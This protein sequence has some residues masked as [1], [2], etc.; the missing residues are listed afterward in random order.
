VLVEGAIHGVTFVTGDEEPLVVACELATRLSVVARVA[1]SVGIDRIVISSAYRNR[2]RESF[3]TMGMALDIPR[4]R[5]NRK[6]RA[7]D[8]E[9]RRWLVIERDFRRSSGSAT[10]VEGSDGPPHEA[11][12]RLD[13]FVCQLWRQGVFASILTPNYNW[14]HRDH[15]HLDIRPD[16]PRTFLR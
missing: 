15:L 9:R 12:R 1:K 2:P 5:M 11:G 4:M 6:V 16:D 3:H 13:A 10:C 14:G 8:G 7:G